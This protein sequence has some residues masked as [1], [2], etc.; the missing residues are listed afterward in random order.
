MS[1]INHLHINSHLQMRFRKTQP[2]TGILPI[3]V[4]RESDFY[5]KILDDTVEYT[6]EWGWKATKA[7]RF[8][9]L[10]S[11]LQTVHSWKEPVI[12]FPMFCSHM[13]H[14]FLL[15]SLLTSTL[16]SHL[17]L[18]V[19]VNTFC[20]LPEESE[21]EYLLGTN[22]SKSYCFCFF[23]K[24]AQHFSMGYYSCSERDILMQACTLHGRIFTYIHAW[25]IY[26]F[27][28]IHELCDIPHFP[29]KTYIGIPHKQSL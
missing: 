19:L 10:L 8:P 24:R 25:G 17:L 12:H 6:K 2:E 18:F 13:Y 9:I 26:L 28:Y 27:T 29:Y 20:V 14:D 11:H 7:T 3:I 22:I 16:H 21:E 15:A 5:L 1:L 23:P 4:V